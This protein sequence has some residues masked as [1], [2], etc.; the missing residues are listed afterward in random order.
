MTTVAQRH[1]A[2]HSTAA[3]QYPSYE[4][5]YSIRANAERPRSVRPTISPALN[6]T[7]LWRRMAT[8]PGLSL[9][10]GDRDS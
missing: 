10:F 8:S 9:P 1:P 3:M 5:R 4:A 6:V 2:M 7:G